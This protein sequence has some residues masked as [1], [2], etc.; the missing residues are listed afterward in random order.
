MR[1]VALNPTFVGSRYVGGADADLILDRR[2]I[3]IKTTTHARLDKSWLLQ[4]LGYVFL[5]W[6]DRYR[7]DGL[8]ILYS[9]QATFARW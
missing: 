4:L 2:L 1:P 9:R 3:E 8:G 7:I 5:D 6:E